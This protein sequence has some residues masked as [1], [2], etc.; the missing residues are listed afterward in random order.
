MVF[1]NLVSPS[2]YR[3]E[4]EIFV[5]YLM[6][7][8]LLSCFL[9]N[10]SRC[11]SCVFVRAQVPQLYRKIDFVRALYIFSFVGVFTLLLLYHTLIVTICFKS[12]PCLPHHV[13]DRLARVQTEI[14]HRTK[15]RKVRINFI[16]IVISIPF[17]RIML[18]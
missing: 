16:F 13:V 10:E 2:F 11:S 6:P 17:R 15:L 14:N 12:Q 3:E 1:D 7:R 5:G 8:T 9:W 18:E 4:L